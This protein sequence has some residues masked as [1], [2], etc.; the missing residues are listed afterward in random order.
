MAFEMIA[1]I[2]VA[3]W[4]GLKL[5]EKFNGGRPLFVVILSILGVFVALYTALR[6]FINFRK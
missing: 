1:I 5:D 4:G 3:V 6:D 2:L